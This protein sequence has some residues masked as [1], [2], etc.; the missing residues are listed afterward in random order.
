MQQQ[1]IATKAVLEAEERERQRIAQ[2]L[3]D[4]VGQMMSAVKLNLS[5]FQSELQITDEQIKNKFENI[6]SLVDDS[7]KEVRSVSHNMMPNA[8][9]KN[10]LST[11][12]REFLNKID[13]NALEVNLYVEGLD[14]HLNSDVEIMLYRVIQE[15]VNNAVKHA[16]ASKLD[17]SIIREEK[18]LSVSIE[19]NGKGFDTSD[20]DLFSGIGLKNIISRVEYLKGNI[21][22]DAKENK[23]TAIIIHVPL[24]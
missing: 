2:D 3:H 18:N 6:F 15:C 17:L 9:L 7:C 22:F 24:A 13:S 8:L 12:V 10:G 20:M 16:G 11:A 4:G 19:D 5:A 14:E 1:D 21:E 23:G